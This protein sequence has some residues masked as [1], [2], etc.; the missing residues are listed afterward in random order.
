MY[1]IY[2]STRWVTTT[3]GY[4]LMYVQKV[5]Q[6]SGC[7]RHKRHQKSVDFELIIVYQS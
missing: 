6:A 2:T 5:L 4:I 1:W 7:P 3:V